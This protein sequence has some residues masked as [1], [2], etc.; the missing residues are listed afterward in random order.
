MVSLLHLQKEICKMSFMKMNE[1]KVNYVSNHTAYCG[2]LLKAT[3]S[4][5]QF[6][7]LR[8]LD[9]III[10]ISFQQIGRVNTVVRERL[11][12]IERFTA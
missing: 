8:L 11:N 3:E 6:T 2:Q 4:N 5:S 12:Y 1:I 9:V 10:E 7:E